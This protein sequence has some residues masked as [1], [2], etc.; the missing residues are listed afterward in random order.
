M[1][2]VCPTIKIRHKDSNDKTVYTIN[3]ADYNK[4]KH[5]LVT[6]G[7]KLPPIDPSKKD[8]L[9]GS[10]KQPATWNVDGKIVQLGDIV[11]QA[12]QESGLSVDEWNK[13]PQDELE[14]KIQVVVDKVI[15]T[16]IPY[17][18]GNRGRGNAM[19]FFIIDTVTGKPVND[20]ETF[21]TEAAAL[22]KINE[23]IKA[24]E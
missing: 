4:D 8:C 20:D 1:N 14:A 18:V 22:A 12:H 21:P 19:K 16:P 6:E 15:P 11:A 5:E 13:L 9:F 2:D 24:K 10:S 17:T 3:M 7:G 23:L